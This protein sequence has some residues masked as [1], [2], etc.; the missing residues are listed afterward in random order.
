M[1]ILLTDPLLVAVKTQGPMGA[2][3]CDWQSG[4][5][6]RRLHKRTAVRKVVEKRSQS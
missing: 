4:S 1:P 6:E 3:E 5:R 2:L